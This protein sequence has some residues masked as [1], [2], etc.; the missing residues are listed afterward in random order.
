MIG[1]DADDVHREFGLA[2]DELP[3][4]LL[5]I[6]VERAGNWEQKPRR[7]LVDVLELV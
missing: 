2:E 4:L 3:V 5:S 1:F 7:P 6:G